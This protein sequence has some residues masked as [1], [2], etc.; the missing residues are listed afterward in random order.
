MNLRQAQDRAIALHQQGRLCEAERLYSEILKQDRA[1][2]A[3]R[4]MLGVLRAQQ[5][6]SLE[7]RELIASVVKTN[8]ND[9]LA[10]S[11]YANV[12]NT[13]E[14]YEDA[15]NF[16]ERALK[17]A[18]DYAQA[19][20]NRGNALQNLGDLAE[21]MASYDH[22]LLLQPQFP[23]ALVNRGNLYR[24][25]GEIGRALIDYEAAINQ[26]PQYGDAYR[27][28]GDALSMLCDYDGALKAYDRAVALEPN[29][30]DSWNN[31]AVTLLNLRLLEKAEED[32]QRALALD[33]EKAEPHL[34]LG[35]LYLL[36]Q[37][38]AKGWPL[39]EWRKKL[40]HSRDR[41]EYRQPLW[42]GEQD[43]ANKTL[44]VYVDAGLGDAIQFYRYAPLARAMGADVVLEANDCLLRLLRG[45]TPAV[46]VVGRDHRLEFDYHIPLLSL[47]HVFANPAIPS[48]DRYLAAEP[49]LKA[50]WAQRIG[51]NGFRVGIAWQGNTGAMGSEGK[52]FALKSLAQIAKLP[53]IRLI[54]LQ[55]NAGAEQL[56]TLPRDMRIERFEDLDSGPDAFLDTAAILENLDLVISCDTAIAHLAGALG[57]AS[58]VA[59]K[60][61]PQW[62]WF[63]DRSDSPWYP[64][65]RLFRQSEPGNWDPVFCKMRDELA[66]RMGKP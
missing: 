17:L 66:G 18:P 2:S 60:Y 46:K 24:R 14:L 54:N 38:F 53:G 65:T 25:Q 16:I 4:H 21:A 49:E 51:K 32:C 29:C 31:R 22:A 28:R 41:R 10:L 8:P 20:N 7:A 44:L 56:Q 48:H 1:N 42:T 12:L 62:H 27:N 33:P 50:K 61:V 19:W 64:R 34:T 26:A 23:I 5:G 47:P 35:I 45:A 39:F 52:S 55:K 57:I 37:N 15:R 43:I 13:L 36:Q 58:W 40:P 59:L 30:A 63:L 6:R 11:N 3:V 9:A